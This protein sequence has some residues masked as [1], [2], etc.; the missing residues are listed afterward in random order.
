MKGLFPTKKIKIFFSINLSNFLIFWVII[1]G[2]KR[3][4]HKETN[5]PKYWHRQNFTE[6]CQLGSTPADGTNT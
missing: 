5:D 3:K 4:W 6:I 2:I 1:Y